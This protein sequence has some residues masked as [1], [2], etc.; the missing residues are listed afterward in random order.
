[1]RTLIATSLVVLA[2]TLSAGAPAVAATPTCSDVLG[3]TVHGQH[4]IGDYLTGIGHDTLDWPPSGGIVGHTISANG[5]IQ[6][7]GGPGPGYH[8]PNG[9][10]P[11]ASFC[12]DSQGINGTDHQRVP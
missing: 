4:I 7:A 5:G 10:A 12:V 3:I 1:M 2:L 8:F 9:F 6:V 11:G